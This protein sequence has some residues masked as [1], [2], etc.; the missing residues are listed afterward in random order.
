MRHTR[1][2]RNAKTIDETTTVDEDDE[3]P[4]A[5]S[6]ATASVVAVEGEAAEPDASSQTTASAVAVEG[7]AGEGHAVESAAAQQYVPELISIDSS[8][9]DSSSSTSDASEASGNTSLGTEESGDYHMG[10]TSPISSMGGYASS[11]ISDNDDGWVSFY[12][13]LSVFYCVRADEYD[14]NVAQQVAGAIVLCTA[15]WC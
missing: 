5:S 2:F 11:F 4:D 3:K 12:F 7:Q 1:V 13:R 14:L 15:F 8:S 9:S 10:R 6:Q